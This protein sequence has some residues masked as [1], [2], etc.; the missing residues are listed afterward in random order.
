MKNSFIR[1][2]RL[3]AIVAGGLSSCITAR[4]ITPNLG[5]GA[6]QP[7]TERSRK[8]QTQ[9]TPRIHEL[10]QY[11]L[12]GFGMSLSWRKP[13]GKGLEA[14]VSR[15]TEDNPATDV[16]TVMDSGGIRIRNRI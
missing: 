6:M 8:L 5:A 16:A 9:P 1:F 14:T 3:A 12:K 15:R 2:G 13:R 11:S 4:G 10:N 7:Q